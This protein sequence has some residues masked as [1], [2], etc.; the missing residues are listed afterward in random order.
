MSDRAPDENLRAWFTRHT[1]DEL[2]AHLAGE[3]LAPV[4]R[5][6][7]TGPVPHGVAD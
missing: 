6:I 7:P 2:R 4:E 1:D 3:V 5:D